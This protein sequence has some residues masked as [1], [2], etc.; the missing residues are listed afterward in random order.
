[1]TSQATNLTIA[2]FIGS[3]DPQSA[4]FGGRPNMRP[5]AVVLSDGRTLMADDFAVRAKE[6]GI[7]LPAYVNA[8]FET[9]WLN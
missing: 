8:G 6:A 5:T 9:D 3:E 1:M 4:Q 7:T 2:G